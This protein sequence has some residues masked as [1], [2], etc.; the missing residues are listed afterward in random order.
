M[1]RAVVFISF[2]MLKLV[3][4][5]NNTFP[6]WRLSNKLFW[7]NVNH[8][9]FQMIHFLVVVQSPQ[10]SL[11]LSYSIFSTIYI[12][13][14]R[15]IITVFRY[16][17]GHC[18]E[19]SYSG[20]LIQGSENITCYNFTNNNCPLYYPSTEAYKCKYSFTRRIKLNLKKMLII[21]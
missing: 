9:T 15:T 10:W 14:E 17:L 2:S 11:C 18:T 21:R 8:A 1:L 19:Y 4:L 13:N 3:H 5:K 20:N 6:K 7:P 12:K 16:I